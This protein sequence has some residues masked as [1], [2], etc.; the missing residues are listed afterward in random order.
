[1]PDLA[2][3]FVFG[4]GAVSAL[5]QDL[6]AHLRRSIDVDFSPIGKP[7]LYFDSK[8]VD[9]YGGPESD[10]FAENGFYIDYVV[11]DLL[12]CTPPGWRERVTILDLA[13][14]LRGHFL[15]AHD[16]AYNK[17]WAGR[18]KDIA[19]VKGLLQTGIITLL[20]LQELHA[21]N[22]IADEDQAKVCR[23]LDAVSAEPRRPTW[24]DTPSTATQVPAA[25]F[26]TARGQ[27]RD[28]H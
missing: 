6:S 13:P 16:I 8:F 5:H 14:G 17:L 25:G 4:S 7:V 11:Q 12:R 9:Q 26:A 27:G 18:P 2:E 21:S 15:D 1:M 28:R 3:V 23:S 24:P 19:W 22:P 10:F 20:R